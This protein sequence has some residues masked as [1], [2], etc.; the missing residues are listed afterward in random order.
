M[1]K[2]DAKRIAW[3]LGLQR[4]LH[5]PRYVMAPLT[6]PFR[7]RGAGL[8]QGA[9][10]PGRA[11]SL[12][13]EGNAKGKPNRFRALALPKL[14]PARSPVSSSPGGT[15]LP[16]LTG[17]VGS[18]QIS[19]AALRRDLVTARPISRPPQSLGRSAGRLAVASQEFS[20]PQVSRRAI[21]VPG[22]SHFGFGGL[23]SL[24]PVRASPPELAI[25]NAP[26]RPTSR[27]ATAANGKII[28]EQPSSIATKQ[29][30]PMQLP[31]SEPELISPD[32]GG[33]AGDGPPRGQPT[34][35]MLH[36]D[37]SALGRWAVQHLER[38]LGKPSTGMTGV[39]PRAALPRSRVAPF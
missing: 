35:S 1:L 19:G 27:S 7:G 17:E 10:T 36:I 9:A 14:G 11:L 3:F 13:G 26:T 34:V 12:C 28:L 5:F 39:D 30:S 18:K 16:R 31:A 20:G 4:I 24:A 32:R 2:P 29:S 21:A 8:S 15:T 37:G 33:T 38:T 22:Y 25:L 6:F 23:G